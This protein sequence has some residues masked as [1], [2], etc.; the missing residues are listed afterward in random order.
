M[1]NK[2]SN[3]SGSSYEIL[4]ED[5][6]ESHWSEYFDGWTITNLEKGEVLLTNPNIDQAGLH[7][8]LNR[9][10]DLNLTLL[11]VSQTE[12]KHG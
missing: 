11:S 12:R 9:I 5:H 7:G 10:R 6:L 8:V 1:F 4:L 2:T 3:N